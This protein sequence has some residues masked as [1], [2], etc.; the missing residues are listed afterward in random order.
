MYVGYGSGVDRLR[1][2]ESGTRASSDCTFLPLGP[3]G[4]FASNADLLE[5]D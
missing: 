3:G 1:Y 5:D 4:T 2:A